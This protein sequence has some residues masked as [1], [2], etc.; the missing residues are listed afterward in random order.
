MS[1]EHGLVFDNSYARLG[2][3]FCTRQG[4]MPVGK[5]GLVRL[6]RALAG[7]L[8]IDA[9]WLQSGVGLDVLAGNVV[10]PGAEPIATVYAGHQF[11]SWNPRLGDG[12]ALLL[13]ELLAPDGERFDLQLKGSGPTAYSR[14]GDGRAPLGPVLREY[15]VSEAMSAL[16][17]PTTRSLAAVLSGETVFRE[18]ALPG[19]VL[20]R[21][22][23][24]HIRIGTL[25]YFAARSDNEALRSLSK[26][27]AERHYPQAATTENPLQA[28]LEGVMERQADLVARWQLIGFIHGVMNTDNMLLS[29][30]T[31]DYGPCAFM[32]QYEPGMVLSSIDHGG[33]YAYGNQPHIAHWNLSMLARCLL[34]LLHAD[35]EKA[36]DIGQAALDTFP[37]R[38]MAAY[39]R[40][41]LNKLGLSHADADTD[42]LVRDL[43]TVMQR[44]ALD[45][46]LT[47]YRLTELAGDVTGHGR[48]PGPP[49]E[50]PEALDA[51]LQRWRH[52]LRNDPADIHVRH[53]AMVKANP[54]F[55]PRNHL[56]EQ[57]L[58][59]AVSER[60]FKPFHRLVDVLERPFDYDPDLAHFA[61]PPRDEEIVRQTFCGT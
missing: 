57:A 39:R 56:V 6:N 37:D 35:P 31:I 7:R 23:R 38:Y 32:D 8:G 49:F 58:D 54:V 10:P 12:R 60:D 41:M 14:G 36:A 34:P 40:G 24:S 13:G 52:L 59:A 29:G 48:S 50:L 44:E 53:E 42:E 25:Q 45:F 21:V 1:S 11:G 61:M 19:A 22:A 46:T 18:T 9:D 33:R 2:E 17:V 43:L 16:G 47:F 28:L 27:V 3:K 51:W 55:I 30:E 20:T 15:V 5:P 26:H 4:P